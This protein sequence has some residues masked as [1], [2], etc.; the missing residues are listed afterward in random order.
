L[1]DADNKPLPPERSQ[2]ALVVVKK[3]GQ[4]R[5]AALFEKPIEK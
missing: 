1:Y 5:W 2:G 3:E 4:W